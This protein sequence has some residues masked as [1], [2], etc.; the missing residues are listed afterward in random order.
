[1]S[2]FTSARNSLDLNKFSINILKCIYVLQFWWKLNT[3]G[4]VKTCP[5]RFLRDYYG[6]TLD[7]MFLQFPNHFPWC[8]RMFP[9]VFLQFPREF[10]LFPLCI[11]PVSFFRFCVLFIRIYNLYLQKH[12]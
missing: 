6:D 7:V 8:F 3:R 10:Q 12:K 1:M 9:L 11:S 4:I 2:G 5:F